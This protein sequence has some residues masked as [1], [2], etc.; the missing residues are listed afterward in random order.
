MKR[1]RK[2]FRVTVH[3]IPPHY[4]INK[5]YTYEEDMYAFSEEGVWKY[6]QNY[7]KKIYGHNEPIKIQEITK[8]EFAGHHIRIK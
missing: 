8:D 7:N 2:Y 5:D 4:P 3:R 6:F 1:E